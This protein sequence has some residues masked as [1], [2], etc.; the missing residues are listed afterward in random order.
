MKK[1]LIV[2]DSSMARMIIQQ[3]LD[4]AGYSYIEASGGAEALATIERESPDL[5]ILDLL[6]PGMQGTNVLEELKAKKIDIPVIVASADIQDSSKQLCYELG[7]KSFI[8][9]PVRNAELIRTIEE[10]LGVPH[11]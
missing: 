1:I 5:M 6:M 7:A 2:D 4:E 11:R 3:I 10:I 8:N 9:K